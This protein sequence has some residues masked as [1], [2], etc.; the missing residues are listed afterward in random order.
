[1]SAI[2]KKIIIRLCYTEFFLIIGTAISIIGL[3]WIIT[4]LSNGEFY[5][6][7][8]A[9]ADISPVGIIPGI[10]SVI[11]I[12]SINNRYAVNQIRYGAVRREMY[13]LSQVCTVITAVL[14]T[15]VIYLVHLV[16]CNV[17]QEKMV[18]NQ[19]MVLICIWTVFVIYTIKN[20]RILIKSYKKVPK[21]SI[22]VIAML[23]II[24]VLCWRLSIKGSIVI[25]SSGKI[26]SPLL[27]WVIVI[28]LGGGIGSFCIWYIR[29]QLRMIRAY[30]LNVEVI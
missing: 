3:L 2:A 28:I 5:S 12:S 29:R 10:I 1:M 23:F 4:C 15:V 25:E 16:I 21:R 11:L 13:Q 17:A 6:L 20:K 30:Y 24:M 7:S 14:D 18:A 19:F 8:V 26:L 9:L 27:I 22:M